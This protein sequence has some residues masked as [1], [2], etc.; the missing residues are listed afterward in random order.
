[1]TI[2]SGID[3][4]A[5]GC[6][7]PSG[8]TLALADIALRTS[9]SLTRI[10]PFCVDRRGFPVKT[11]H[12]SQPELD[13][14]VVRWQILADNALQDALQYAP[15]ARTLPSRL[16]LVLPPAERAGVPPQLVQTLTTTLGAEL[17]GCR[18]VT[19]CRGS[20][21]E[22]IAAI[23]QAMQPL[24]VVEHRIDIVLAVDTWQ[25]PEALMWL[26][27]E[28][29]L[30]GSYQ[31]AGPEARP[32][33][34]GRVPGE[35][36]AVIIL[37][38]DSGQ[39]GWCAID[40]I[41]TAQEHILRNDD[42]PCIGLGLTQAARMAISQSKTRHIR[43][44]VTDINGEPYRSDEYGFTALRLNASLNEQIE[45]IAPVLTTGDLGCASAI[46]HMALTALQLKQS[47]INA[48]EHHLILSSSDDER[49]SAMVL[50]NTTGRATL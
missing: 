22:G 32:N 13:F 12:F 24:T 3:I 46:T 43:H 23:E 5:A 41:A 16:W 28:Q 17:P 8:P 10:H 45:R 38:T 50:G 6:A 19:I 48:D 26:E 25:H 2:S 18:D 31:A 14:S 39:H 29:L 44:V 1:M 11:S 36:A 37:A 20:H 21:A 35:G 27:Q 4:I 7:F 33:P 40:G 34:Y 49:R 30:H 42:R 15:F 9:L 47:S